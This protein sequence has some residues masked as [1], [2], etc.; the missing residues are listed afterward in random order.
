MRLNP[1]FEPL[2]AMQVRTQ[3]GTVLDRVA[4]QQQRFAIQRRGKI[5]ALL[6]PVSDGKNINTQAS[7][8]QLNRTYQA[9]DNIK[10]IITDPSLHDASSTIDNYLYGEVSKGED[11]R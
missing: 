5:K 4:L 10:G 11:A 6:V 2:D 3:F 7:L 1:T 8:D 9:L